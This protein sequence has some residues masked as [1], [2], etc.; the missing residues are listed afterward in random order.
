MAHTNEGSK[1]GITDWADKSDGSFKRQVSSFRDA[2][3]EGGKFPPEKG[4][5]HLYVSLACPWAHRALIVRQLKGLESFIDVS[6]VHPHMLEGGW[7]FVTP[8]NAAKP[9]A[10]ASAHSSET[11]P[12]ATADKVHGSGRLADVYRRA[13]PAYDARFTVPVVWDTQTS[14]IVNN[15]SSE[16]IRFLNTAF[17]AQLAGEEKAL[18]LYPPELRAEIDA[19]NEWVYNDVNN[20]VYK[21]GFATTQD[22][23]EKAVRPLAKSL[24]RLEDLL[25]D[26]REF[27]VGGKLTEA[28]VRLY[29]TIVRYDPVYYVHFKCNFGLIRHD[30][31]HLHRWLQRLYWNHPA[32]K[33]TTDFAHIKEHYYFSHPHIN[34]HRI[35]PFGPNVDIEPL[36]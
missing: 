3:E 28:D 7:H 23:Y 18:D 2:I 12:G 19:L 16:I 20:G 17:N 30:Y 22:A 33:D 5:Y 8:E 29:T 10:A 27:L 35:V 9:P 24:G 1:K 34:P 31:P 21:S 26:G 25:A 4:R 15:E 11:F 6:T 32:F 13:D 36:K 14:T